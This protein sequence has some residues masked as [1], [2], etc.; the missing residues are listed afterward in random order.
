MLESILATY[1]LNPTDVYV[2]AAAIF[3]I[4]SGG[5]LLSDTLNAIK[6]AYK[7]ASEDI[8]RFSTSEC[9]YR[10]ENFRR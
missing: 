7:D 9:Q 8:K 5:I 2:T 3:A 4:R 1:G 6:R 10:P